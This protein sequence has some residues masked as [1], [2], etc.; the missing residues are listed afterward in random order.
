MYSLGKCLSLCEIL[1]DLFFIEDFYQSSIIFVFLSPGVLKIFA[2]KNDWMNFDH[3]RE[4]CHAVTSFERLYSKPWPN[5]KCLTTKHHQTLFGDQ[6]FYRLANLFDDVWSCLNSIKH[7]IKQHQTF[8][9]FLCLFRDF[10][11]VGPGVSNMFGSQIPPCWNCYG[12]L[13]NFV[14]HNSLRSNFWW[15]LITKQVTLEPFGQELQTSKCLITKQCLMT[16]GRQTFP[17]W[18]G[19]KR[20][21]A[22]ANH[23]A[24]S[25]LVI[26]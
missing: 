23:S 8:V 12:T 9:L 2:G 14:A 6:T 17:V 11:F 18:P 20:L 24:R 22:S 19:V 10:W 13:G 15:C 3:S 16:L 5:G 21:Q 26:V 1:S 7:S 25:I 4:S